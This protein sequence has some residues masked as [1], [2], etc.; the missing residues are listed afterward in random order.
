MEPGKTATLSFDLKNEGLGNA[1]DITVSLPQTSNFIVSDSSGEF[2]INNLASLES[3]TLTFSITVSPDAIIGTTTI[4]V[5]LSYYDETRTN[6]YNDTKQIG[7]LITGK[8]NFIVTADS[9]DVLT[10]GTSGSITF[11]IANAGNE[12]AD[13]LTVKAIP[14]NNFDLS[15]TSIYIGNLKSDDYDSEKLTLNVGQVEP[16]NYPISLQFSYKD[17]FGRSYN[18]IYSVNAKVSSKAEY[19][20]AHQL[21]SPLPTF[22]IVIVVIIL[23]FIAYRKGYLNKLFRR[24]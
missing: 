16:G 18:E 23:F 20:V 12:E 1:K 13:Y 10:T 24:K 4:P 17:S 15:P 8:Y 5:Q 7:T 21:Q 11:K 22:V 19:S 14:P 6:N 3:K 9:Q 2:F